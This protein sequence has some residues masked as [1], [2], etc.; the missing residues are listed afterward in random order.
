MLSVLLP[1]TVYSL[2]QVAVGLVNTL[3]RIELRRFIKQTTRVTAPTE[4]PTPP[5]PA[6][7]NNFLVRVGS[8]IHK[9]D[10]PPRT[11]PAPSGA[12]CCLFCA[13]L[14]RLDSD[15]LVFVC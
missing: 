12:V 8:P 2:S 7:S 4:T 15:L 5:A 10:A 13:Q 6:K 1:T 9:S 3:L 11:P 14:R